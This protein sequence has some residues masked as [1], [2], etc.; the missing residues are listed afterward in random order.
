MEDDNEFVLF[1]NLDCLNPASLKNEEQEGEWEA[2]LVLRV[3][4]EEVE[5][6]INFNKLR[7][8]N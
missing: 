3:K 8:I 1:G 2:L 4:R 7:R 6:V 5:Q